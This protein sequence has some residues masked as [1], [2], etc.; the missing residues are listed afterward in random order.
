MKMDAEYNETIPA[1]SFDRFHEDFCFFLQHRVKHQTRKA[2]GS[3]YIVELEKNQG[4]IWNQLPLKRSSQL[5]TL[6]F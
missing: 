4:Q 5:R 2:F 3:T 6:P 1:I